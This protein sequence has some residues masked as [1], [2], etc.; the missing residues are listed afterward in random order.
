M[1]IGRVA[2]RMTVAEEEGREE[3][4]EG[5]KEL[6]KNREKAVV[7]VGEERRMEG[8]KRKTRGRRG[9]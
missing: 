4:G 9:C 5:S 3:A 7:V 1:A 2:A 8:T 6:T